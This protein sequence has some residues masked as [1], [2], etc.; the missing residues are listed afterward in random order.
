MILIL[1]SGYAGSAFMRECEARGLPYKMASR[2][3]LTYSHYTNDYI[4]REM[5][6]G[7]KPELVINCAAFIPIRSVD[8]CKN[9]VGE[10]IDVNLALPVMLATVCE[11]EDVPLAHLSTAC[12]YNDAHEYTEEDLP[13]RDFK[14]YCGFYLRTKYMS[15]RA[16][17]Q[18][19]KSYVWRIRLPFD[20]QNHLKNY[21][22]KLGAFDKVWSHTNSLSHRG[23][24][25][26]ACL[27]MWEKRV[28]CGVY[29]C[30][31]KGSISAEQIISEMVSYGIHNGD[32][33]FVPGPVTGS[34]LS[35]AK[36][37]ATGVKIRH[38]REALEDSLKNWTT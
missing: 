2:G 8:D 3:P 29:N 25:V 4:F 26:K 15:E 9:H 19:P 38:V 30:V 35:T 16:L 32:C 27:D 23:D 11:R 6:R 18:Y 24:Y 36:L 28:P 34:T 12:L 13:T 5:L 14:G 17:R 22:S 20:E 1:G 33:E 37:E 21:L 10:T 7:F 31:N